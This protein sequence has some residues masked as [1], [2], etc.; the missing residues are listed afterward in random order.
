MLSANLISLVS[1]RTR[2]R[3]RDYF[4]S[5]MV[6]LDGGDAWHADAT[7]RGSRSYDVNLSREHDEIKA[8]CTCSNCEQYF[9]PCEHIW[10][11][12][13]AAESQGYLVGDR[14]RT[15]RHLKV[16][17]PYDEDD[18]EIEVWSDTPQPSHPRNAITNSRPQSGQPRQTTQAWK[19][20]LSRLRLDNPAAVGDPRRGPSPWARDRLRRRYPGVPGG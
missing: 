13:L 5:R 18:L 1:K 9:Q 14:T 17:P 15:P 7:V 11:T 3:G 12:L 20:T 8:W 4:V 10:A 19:E 16:V 6:K 2:E